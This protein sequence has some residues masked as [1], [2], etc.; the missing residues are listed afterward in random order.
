MGTQRTTLVNYGI[1]LL[2]PAAEQEPLLTVV[3]NLSGFD[4]PDLLETRK[5]N[6]PERFAPG[7]QL[8]SRTEYIERTPKVPLTDK[9]LDNIEASVPGL[10]GATDITFAGVR[11]DEA[12][13]GDR[14]LVAVPN[15]EGLIEL[16]QERV[17]FL[18][19]LQRKTGIDFGPMIRRTLRTPMDMTLFYVSREAVVSDKQLRQLERTSRFVIGEVIELGQAE[20]YP[21]PRIDTTES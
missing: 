5:F 17:Q 12:R 8:V 21:D 3:S 11:I 14:F 9:L 13:N 1:G 7:V 18:A 16:R 6:D 15:D 4:V 20:I 19:A 2:R 10:Q